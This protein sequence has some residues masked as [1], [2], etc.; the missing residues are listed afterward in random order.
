MLGTIA[1]GINGG[2]GG[3]TGGASGPATSGGAT[4]NTNTSDGGRVNI[5]TGGGS[6]AGG[7]GDTTGLPVWIVA[8]TVGAVALVGV[9]FALRK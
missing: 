4:Y 3:M 2:A 1:G 7:S 6:T 9:V 8:A 5:Q